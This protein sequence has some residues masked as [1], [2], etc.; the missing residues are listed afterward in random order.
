MDFPDVLFFGNA[1]YLLIG[2][3]LHPKAAGLHAQHLRHAGSLSAVGIKI[4]VIFI[5]RVKPKLCEKIYCIFYGKLVQNFLPEARIV[6]S[7]SV[8]LLLEI[9]EIAFSVSGGADFFAWLF[10]LFQNGYGC[11]V[12]RRCNRSHQA[13]GTAA[14]DYNT[15]FIHINSCKCL[16]VCLKKAPALL[17]QLH[18]ILFY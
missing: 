8:S 17:R 3:D 10:I 5:Y 9:G 11:A 13:G 2:F 16:R 1:F 4:S 14:Y 18:Q 7:V 6:A 12:F 15:F